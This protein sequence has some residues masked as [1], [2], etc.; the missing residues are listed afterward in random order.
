MYNPWDAINQ[1]LQS[2][3]QNQINMFNIARQMKLDEM[4]LLFNK[5]KLRELEETHQERQE[6]RG[7]K[8]QIEQTIGSVASEL[9][10]AHKQS[11]EESLARTEEQVGW[12]RFSDVEKPPVKAPTLSDII[13]KSQKKALD[14]SNYPLYVEFT[15]M[16]KKLNLEEMNLQKATADTIKSV[17]TAAS[18]LAKIDENSARQLIV[19]AGSNFGMR[20]SPENIKFQSGMT[21]VRQGDLYV[22]QHPDG[23]TEVRDVKHS[24]SMVEELIKQGR[25][26]EALELEI[27]LR[28]K[29]GNESIRWAQLILNTANS[30]IRVLDTE[31]KEH[32]KDLNKKYEIKVTPWGTEEVVILDGKKKRPLSEQEAETYKLS[33]QKIEEKQRERDEL[34]KM[35]LDYQMSLIPGGQKLPQ[36]GKGQPTK[37]QTPV[38][39]PMTPEKIKEI[40]DYIRTNKGKMYNGIPI[41]KEEKLKEEGTNNIV[42]GIWGGKYGWRRKD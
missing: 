4:N 9:H 38:T 30:R 32:Q 16:K 15:N 40:D 25:F 35:V 34:S 28:D 14:D 7:L 8:K 11:T 37:K 26:K 24:K 22:I 31:I 19:N 23:K 2:F 20:I 3:V 21:I 13:D 18:D 29:G 33:K 36:P 10:Q 27:K 41:G 39:P 12:D 1:S 42:T 6:Q 5:V 17:L